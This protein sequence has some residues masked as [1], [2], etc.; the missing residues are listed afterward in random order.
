[1]LI[2]GSFSTTLIPG[3]GAGD[4]GMVGVGRVEK[5]IGGEEEE[6]VVVVPVLVPLVESVS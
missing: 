1:M 2:S 4:E 3:L 5:E 6:V